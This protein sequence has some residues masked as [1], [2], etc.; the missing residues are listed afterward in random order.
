MEHSDCATRAISTE[1]LGNADGLESLVPMSTIQM[2]KS[3]L[4][5]PDRNNLQTS[6]GN[7]LNENEE[8]FS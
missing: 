3:S 1:P 4:D 8:I 7:I 2:G 5:P 6:E